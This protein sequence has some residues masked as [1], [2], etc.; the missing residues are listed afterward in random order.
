MSPLPRYHDNA[1]SY[2]LGVEMST[3]P[4]G[5]PVTAAGRRKS[6]IGKRSRGLRLGA[7]LRRSPRAC[8]PQKTGNVT[9]VA[10]STG[11]EGKI[12]KVW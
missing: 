7:L 4:G 12:C 2:C 10:M 5:W 8:L 9:S 1:P 11:L 6:S 3:L